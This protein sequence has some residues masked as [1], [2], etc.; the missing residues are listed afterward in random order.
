MKKLI[1]IIIILSSLNLNAQDTLKPKRKITTDNFLNGSLNNGNTTNP[2]LAYNGNNTLII[3]KLEINSTI[4][5]SSR[6]S[7][8][9]TQNEINER[10]NISHLYKYLYT[11]CTHQYNY[12]LLRKFKYDNLGGFGFGFKENEGNFK[13]SLS[14]GILIQQTQTFND[15]YNKNIRQSFRIK[16]NLII[17]KLIIISSEY[18]YQPSTLI[19]DYYIMGNTKITFKNNKGITINFQDNINYNNISNIKLIHNFNIGLG[20]STK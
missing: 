2:N 6:F 18:Y 19:N 8:I 14:Y 16:Y 5:Y 1:K 15:I 7:P 20:F 9:M 11:F 10:L 17:N 13:F 4:T 12:S 3:N